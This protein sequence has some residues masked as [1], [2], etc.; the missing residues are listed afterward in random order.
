MTAGTGNDKK[1]L[2]NT[3]INKKS[4]V[5]ALEE[6]IGIVSTACKEVGISRETHY[7]WYRNDS[8]YAKDVDSVADLALD[9]AESS[10]HQ[11]IKAGNPTSTIFFLKTKGKNRGYIEHTV[12]IDQMN[13]Q[14]NNV[15]NMISVDPSILTIEQLEMI[16]KEQEAQQEAPQDD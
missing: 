11:Q 1:Q 7:K 14:N 6:S 15:T 13:V 3:D 10:L 8:D 12:Q 16:K 5:A 4:M 2:T 9:F